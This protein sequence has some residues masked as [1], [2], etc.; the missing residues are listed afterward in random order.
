[1][2]GSK[3]YKIISSHSL[4]VIKA[5]FFSIKAIHINSPGTVSCYLWHWETIH[6][7]NNYK[8]NYTKWFS[9]WNRVLYSVH[10]VQEWFS[11]RGSK[12]LIKGDRELAECCGL[13]GYQRNNTHFSWKRI[14]HYLLDELQCNG[15]EGVILLYWL[16]NM[17]LPKLGNYRFII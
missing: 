2:P 3:H 8:N 1:M 10:I 9:H 4:K 13:I 14:N 5:I 7:R 12:I 15:S 16:N 11:K 17:C 6:N